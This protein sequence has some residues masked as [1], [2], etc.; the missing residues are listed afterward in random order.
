MIFLIISPPHF[1]LL[2][3]MPLIALTLDI[4]MTKRHFRL[5]YIILSILSNNFCGSIISILILK[6]YKSCSSNSM[7]QTGSPMG[8]CSCWIRWS[9]GCNDQPGLILKILISP[10]MLQLIY[11]RWL[12]SLENNYLTTQPWLRKTKLCCLTSVNRFWICVV[13]K[14]SVIMERIVVT[15]WP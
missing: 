4:H 5:S 15:I 11:R 9:L 10:L 14:L 8:I 13:Q 12:T 3:Y 1:W 6:G 2:E 7:L